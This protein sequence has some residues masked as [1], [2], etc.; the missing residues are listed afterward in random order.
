MEL[1][2]PVTSVGRG[3]ESRANA[4]HERGSVRIPGHQEVLP[5]ARS[6]DEVEACGDSLMVICQCAV[7]RRVVAP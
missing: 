1:N 5:P 3:N 2:G 4:K 6:A 7:A